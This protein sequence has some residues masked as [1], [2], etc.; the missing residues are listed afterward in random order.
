MIKKIEKIVCMEFG[1]EPSSI[2]D[3]SRRNS[4]IRHIITT[5]ACEVGLSCRDAGRYYG[6]N[7]STIVYGRKRIYGFC[8]IYPQEKALI[9]RLRKM[10]KSK[11]MI[12]QA[13]QHKKMEVLKIKNEIAELEKFL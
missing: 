5:L 11:K 13:I 2:H 10:I 4:Y 1:V 12:C 6:R 3:S 8:D 7:H 9:A